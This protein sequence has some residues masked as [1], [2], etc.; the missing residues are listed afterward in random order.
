ML[1]YN[2]V[3]SFRA[4]MRSAI[5]RNYR[6]AVW[7]HSAGVTKIFTSEASTWY[8]PRTWSGH[9]AQSWPRLISFLTEP[10]HSPPR[11]NG[12]AKAHDWSQLPSD[13]A[14]QYWKHWNYQTLWGAMKSQRSAF[15]IQ[16]HIQNRYIEWRV[17]WFS[18]SWIST[19]FKQ[20]ATHIR[21]KWPRQMSN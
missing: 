17:L 8:C 1:D 18:V 5:F 12:S 2:L 3:Q 16:G 4:I 11:P 10:A 14:G 13:Q 9:L 21:Q 20:W 6:R 15:G 7:N 19:I